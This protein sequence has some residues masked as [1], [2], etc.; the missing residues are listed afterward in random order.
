[1]MVHTGIEPM[2][3]AASPVAYHWRHL[4]RT[5]LLQQ[6]RN[7]TSWLS[8]G[9][10]MEP[11]HD[12]GGFAC[13]LQMRGTGCAFEFVRGYAQYRGIRNLGLPAPGRIESGQDLMPTFSNNATHYGQESNPS[14]A[15]T[16][17]VGRNHPYG[18]IRSRFCAFQ[19]GLD[20]HPHWRR[21]ITSSSTYYNRKTPIFKHFWGIFSR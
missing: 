17:Q 5:T 13:A 10:K 6:L 8:N 7:R 1:M 3:P 21:M 11:H 20:Q 12:P 16:G 4:P 19:H 18:T 2:F 15:L 14:I 9:P